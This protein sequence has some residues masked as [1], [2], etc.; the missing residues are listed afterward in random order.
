MHDDHRSPVVPAGPRTDAD[1]GPVAELRGVGHRFGEAVALRDLS[2]AVPDGRITVLLGPNGAGKT[3]A[4]RAIT[5]ALV[6]TEGT[7]RTFGLS[8]DADGHLVRPRCGVV[9]AKP[10]LY[11]RLSGRE[12]L[13]YAGELY[14]VTEGLDARVEDAAS[15]FGISDALD[16][17]VGGYSTGMKTRLALARSILHDPELLLFDEPTSG[18]DPES[19]HAVLELIR[20]MT[21]DGRTVVMCTHLLSEAEGLADHIVVMEGGTVLVSGSPDSLTDRYWPHAVVDLA[22]EDGRLLDRVS[23]WPG[24]VAYRRDAGGA[25]IE[26]DDLARVPNLIAALVADGVRL[27]RVDPHQPTLEDLYFTIRRQAGGR[28]VAERTDA[29]APISPTHPQPATAPPLAE[30]SPLTGAVVPD[31][32]PLPTEAIA[33]A[34]MST[35]LHES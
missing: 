26:L 15:R 30:V 19:A 21:R 13:V 24:V 11:D 28:E 31:H 5:G 8:P 9:S 20:E 12:N 3:T 23:T 2:I 27:T 16:Q 1:P 32:P 14:G 25:R 7:V 35:D 33:P 18:L 22:A 4:I 10:A 17:L 29:L 34:P 6:P